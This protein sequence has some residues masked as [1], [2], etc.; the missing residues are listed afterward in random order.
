MKRFSF[1][2]KCLYIAFYLPLG[3]V[4]FIGGV[5]LVVKGDAIGVLV[6]SVASTAIV[7]SV[8]LSFTLED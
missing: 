3:I 5:G 8:G 2:W 6:C 1:W 4:F 7:T